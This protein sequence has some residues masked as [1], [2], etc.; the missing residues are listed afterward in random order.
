MI[1][2]QPLRRPRQRRFASLLLPRPRHRLTLIN[3]GLLYF[4]VVA[5][6]SCAHGDKVLATNRLRSSDLPCAKKR[7]LH[8]QVG[9]T[10]VIGSGEWRNLPVLTTVD[11]VAPNCADAWC[12]TSSSFPTCIRSGL[13]I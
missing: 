11:T 2:K 13:R 12:F 10:A 8:A 7:R 4:E 1:S 3:T 5:W 9:T 6:A